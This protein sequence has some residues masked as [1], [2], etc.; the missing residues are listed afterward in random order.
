K[1]IT[2]D[3]KILWVSTTKMPLFDEEGNIAGT[4]GISR[5]ITRY[6]IAEEKIKSLARFPDE[7]PNAVLRV[8]KNCEILYSN[9]PGKALEKFIHDGEDG[10]KT[11]IHK[12]I[13]EA[14]NTG[15]T[16]VFD[17]KLGD[18]TYSITLSPVE[19][20]GYINLYAMDITEKT[21]M[22]NQ[23]EKAVEDLQRSNDDLQQFA[24][25]ASHDLQEPLRMVTSYL[26]LLAKRYQGKLDKDADDFIGFAVDGAKRMQ[27]LIL[28]L[29]QY[30]RVGSQAKPFAVCD[31][32][33]VAKNCIKDL[34]AAIE[35]NKAEV[36][37]DKLPVITADIT[38]ME[39]LLRNLINNALK[40]H[41]ENVT[42][43]IHVGVRE[44]EDGWTFSV[45][46]NGIGIAPE[47][48]NRIFVI[49]Q[50]LH[51]RNEYSGSGIGLSVCKRVVE[52]H[53]GK[54]WVKSTPGKGATF[55]FTIPIIA[56]SQETEE[57][58]L[59]ETSS[60]R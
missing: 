34:E 31:M 3:G 7:N 46:D 42:P 15:Q 43:K 12:K 52:R 58:Q 30:S 27:N 55:Y 5:D 28:A 60:V 39:Q 26:Q 29:L 38:Q 37:Y 41:A 47:F 59:C 8:N 50:R 21:Q 17:H 6:Q 40:Y 19:E 48:F 57:E 45:K 33:K 36:T 11:E 22:E 13:S 10:R 24:H 16:I 53:G 18:R 20:S 51:N 32:D 14:Y 23:L 4:F 49:F 1:Q 44:E 9:N 54:I 56:V 25:V 2:K 35:Q